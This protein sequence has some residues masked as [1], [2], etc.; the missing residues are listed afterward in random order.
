MYG[1]KSQEGFLLRDYFCCDTNELRLQIHCRPITL[2]KR[3]ACLLHSDN[4]QVLASMLQ[5]L[6]HTSTF[7]FCRTCTAECCLY[8]YVQADVWV[9]ECVC[10]HSAIQMDN[11]LLSVIRCCLYW[12]ARACWFIT[13]AL[14]PSSRLDCIFGAPICHLC[15]SRIVARPGVRDLWPEGNLCKQEISQ[16]MAKMRGE[17]GFKI[18]VFSDWVIQ[19]SNVSNFHK[20]LQ[21]TREGQ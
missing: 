2:E 16:G 14:C 1:D 7:Y 18:S 3:H 10:Y 20:V 19:G 6:L 5:L 13:P 21:N 8:T 9:Y 12:G 4:Q 15:I 17:I 11:R